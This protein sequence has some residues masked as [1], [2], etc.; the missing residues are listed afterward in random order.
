[1]CAVK[2]KGLEY[3]VDYNDIKNFFKG[4][5]YV[6]NSVQLGLNRE[7]RNNGF[8]AILFN[9]EEDAQHAVEDLNEK[10]IG[11]RWVELTLMSYGDYREFN[12]SKYT[13]YG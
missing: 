12:S 11:N 5:G 1:M 2:I 10:Y 9:K 13:G 8:G 6:N 3:N 7:G 4:C